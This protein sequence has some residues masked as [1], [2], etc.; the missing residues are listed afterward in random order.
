M[1]YNSLATGKVALVTGAGSG[2]GRAIAMLLAEEGAR[3]IAVLDVN[4]SA[5]VETASLLGDWNCETL[6]IEADVANSHDVNSAVDRI[7]SE[8]GSLDLAINNAGIR[9]DPVQIADCPDALWQSVI[10][11]NLSGMFYCLRAEIRAMRDHRGGSIVNI[12]SGVVADPVPSLGPYTASKFGVAGLTRAVAGEC[13]PHNIRVNAVLPGSTD[14]P[15][16]REY[17]AM[18]PAAARAANR[19]PMRRFGQPR[20][21]AEAVVWLCSDH[22]SFIHGATLLADGGSHAFAIPTG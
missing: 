10:D 2:I 14:T 12:S 19:L 16:Q 13:T 18:N 6:V 22:S 1:S 8:F 7:M 15:L 9:G 5:A 3:S 21:I 17:V 20:E 4:E 11:T